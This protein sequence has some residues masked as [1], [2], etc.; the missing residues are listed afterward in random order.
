M[1]NARALALAACL[2]AIAAAPAAAERI[3]AG[4]HEIGVI[5][6]EPSGLSY[7]YWTAWNAAVDFGLAW[8]F[9]NDGN[10]HIHADY[11]LHNF[12]FF[13]DDLENFPLYAGIGGRVRLDDDARIGLRIVV[14]AEYILEDTPLAFFFEIAPILDFAPET[15]ADVNGGLGLRYVF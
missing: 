4:D 1:T 7:K 15:E 12:D 8:S 10:V 14:G 13:E 9:G 3:D 2:L 11:L 6:G 5:L